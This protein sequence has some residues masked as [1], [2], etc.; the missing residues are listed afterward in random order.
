[1]NRRGFIAA[2][3][4]APLVGMVGNETDPVTCTA[5]YRGAYFVGR[6]SGAIEWYDLTNVT[7]E[8]WLAKGD[9]FKYESIESQVKTC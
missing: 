1:M 4:A 7:T 3:V 5:V 8:K 9:L 6:Q 2:C